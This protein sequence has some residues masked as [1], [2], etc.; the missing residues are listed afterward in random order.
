[1]KKIFAALLALTLMIG[2][3]PAMAL[4][5]P[6]WIS[7][8]QYYFSQ[9][10]PEHKAAWA[11]NMVN[12]MNYPNQTKS[13]ARSFYHQALGPMI[14]T[15]NPRIFWVDWIDTNGCLRY[16]T[17][18]EAHY[19][20]MQLPEGMTLL[21]YQVIYQT[22]ADAAINAVKAN[23][24]ANPSR[25]EIVE[26]IFWWLYNNNEYN[27]SQTALNKR[28][29]DPVLFEYLA[30]HSSYSALIPGDEYEPVC[31]G[32]AGA[33]KVMCDALG[34]PCVSVF[35]GCNGAPNHMWNHVQM[36]D[37]Q[38]YLMDVTSLDAN[39]FG[40]FILMDTE[41]AER[42]GYKPNPY[43][44]SGVNPDSGYTEGAA[45]TVPELAK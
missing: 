25:E 38:W 36:D 7:P 6:E 28:N 3:I 24:S 30:A 5:M 10:S 33:F 17:G 41:L 2:C 31:E 19:Q 32:Y 12:A 4:S 26:E 8:D 34:V 15:D 27:Y 35:G 43:M 9:L 20:P 42:N 29:H 44:G 22:M 21:A 11:I 18:S 1:M 13:T 40:K 39:N 16:E 37:G 45:F 23:L 14:K